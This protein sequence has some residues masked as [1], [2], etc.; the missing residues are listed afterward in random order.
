MRKT[1]SPLGLGGAVISSVVTRFDL[2]SDQQDLVNLELKWLFSA[3]DTFLK[4]QQKEAPP[5]QPVAVAIPATAKPEAASN[6]LLPSLDDFEMQFW[7]SQIDS[8]LKRIK[9]HLRNLDILLEQEATQGQAGRGDVSL[10]NQIRSER[11]GIVKI[12][13]ELAQLMNQAYGVMVTSPDQ[14]VE[15]LS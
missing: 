12:L 10:Q 3:A 15:L 6:Q 2:P 11:I 9:I 5:G 8:A 1:I 13:Q 4:I 14:L 7:E